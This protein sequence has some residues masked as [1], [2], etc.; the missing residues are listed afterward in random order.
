MENKNFIET[1]KMYDLIQ[2]IGLKLMMKGN[3]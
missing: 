2:I 3:L 1:A